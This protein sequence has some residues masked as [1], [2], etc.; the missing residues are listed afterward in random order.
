VLARRTF[1]LAMAV[2]G[3][4][5][6][7]G[8]TKSGCG[9]EP[10]D[11][12]LGVPIAPLFLLLRSDIQKDLGLEPAQ[13]ALV[14]RVASEF[15]AKALSLKGK[16]GPGL[17]AARKEI[18][19]EEKNWMSKH[20]NPKQRERLAQIDLQWEGASALLNRP[21]VV[22]YLGLSSEK[23][24]EVARVISDAGALRARAGRLTYEE[25]VD[26]TRKAIALLSEKQRKQWMHVL[27]PP[28]RFIIAT[29]SPD[30]E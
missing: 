13:I 26:V 21:V 16:K 15:Y 24:T 20:L 29:A 5:A 25:H 2:L 14:N 4:G 18:D 22:E 6:F 8:L 3:A 28:C 19:T 17:L 1:V 30:H 23:Q 9:A 11:D 27:G 7:L 12:R 10:L